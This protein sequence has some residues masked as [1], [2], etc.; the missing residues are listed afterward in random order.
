MDDYRNARPG[1][2][3]MLMPRV[4][5]F[6]SVLLVALLAAT[7]CSSDGF[8]YIE[9]KDEG[10][11]FKV[12]DEW[13]VSE[14]TGVLETTSAELTRVIDGLSDPDLPLQPEPWL[15]S[16]AG[17]ASLIPGLSVVA[18]V[19]PIGSDLRDIVSTGWMKSQVAGGLDPA[20]QAAIDEGYTVLYDEDLVQGDHTGNRIVV[21]VAG[22]NGARLT[23]DQLMY[24]DPSVTRAYRLSVLC[25]QSCYRQNFDDIDLVMNSFTVGS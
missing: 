19:I 10:L 23:I 12:P 25:D 2:R 3:L 20:S 11:Y 5:R 13:V 7:A 18:Q 6:V 4:G 16:I 17:D 9:N 21:N 15:V 14:S 24:I 8:T 22:D 1:E